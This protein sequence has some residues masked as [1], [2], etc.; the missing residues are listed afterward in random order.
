M[1]SEADALVDGSKFVF[2]IIWL[3]TFINWVVAFFQISGWEFVK[4]IID[5]IACFPY[6][7]FCFKASTTVSSNVGMIPM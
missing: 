3:K 5:S 1:T 6:S 2:T 7:S 4:S